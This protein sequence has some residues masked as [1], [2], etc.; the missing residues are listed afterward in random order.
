MGEDLMRLYGDNLELSENKLFLELVNV[1]HYYNY[2]NANGRQM[3]Y[4]ET[5]EE[6]EAV[7]EMAK[8]LLL[9]P[10]KAKYV[11][12]SKGQPTFTGH[13]A[14]RL[15]TGEIV[16]GT[17]PIGVHYEVDIEERE[18]QTCDKKTMVLPCLVAKQRIWKEN[19]NAVAAIRRLFALGKLH[20]SWE[21]EVYEYEY[22]NG[23]KYL[24]DYAFKGNAFLGE[25]ARAAYGEDAKVIALAT[26]GDWESE[27][28]ELMIAQAVSQDLIENEDEV[29]ELAKKN[30]VALPV[31]EAAPVPEVSTA[32]GTQD[33]VSEQL[34]VSAVADTAPGVEAT[35]EGVPT[36]EGA[37]LT[38]FD[39]RR[40]LYRA[41]EVALETTS[42]HIM[43]WF[44]EERVVWYHKW[45]SRETEFIHVQYTVVDN[46]VT[47]EEMI[48]MEFVLP[49]RELN[50]AVATS[51][52][53]VERLT[54]EVAE[55]QEYKEKY[56]ASE[57]LKAQ[58][59][60]DE[61]VASLRRMASDCGFFSA[62]ELAETTMATMIAELRVNDVKA[63]IADRVLASKNVEVA[64]T[65]TVTPPAVKSTLEAEVVTDKAALMT[66]FLSRA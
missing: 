63:L 66:S 22:R 39:L 61:E 31:V 33:G 27:D 34:D 43:F 8:T 19:K 32:T 37:S 30:E 7:L 5:E 20:N 10:V 26:E 13:E 54:A 57:L 1:V 2:P 12:N 45:E 23:V 42:G 55:L 9:M 58:A 60:R 3:D 51:K 48:P 56:E 25:S 53:A 64:E 49:I 6:H 44:P 4:G 35:C 50:E 16:Y 28:C 46:E 59:Q 18:V 52:S 21:V 15:A 17:T 29:E 41:I 47:I 11:T 65:R 62:E 24:I 36:T 14:T 38:E 40:S